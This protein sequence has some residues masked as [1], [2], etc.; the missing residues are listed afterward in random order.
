MSKIAEIWKSAWE[1][2][3]ITCAYWTDIIKMDAKLEYGINI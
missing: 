1:N 2:Q 3:K